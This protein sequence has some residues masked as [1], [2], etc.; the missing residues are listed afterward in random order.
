MVSFVVV[1]V[2]FVADKYRRL[3]VR[4]SCVSRWCAAYCINHVSACDQ[5]SAVDAQSKST[6]STV[7][8]WA[9]ES[10]L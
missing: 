6:E 5:R 7:P 3:D 1:I 2:V 4:S 10:C 8:G 9:A